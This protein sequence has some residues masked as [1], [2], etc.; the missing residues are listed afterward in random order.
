MFVF[1][2]TVTG[3]DEP[4]GG[5]TARSSGRHTTKAKHSRKKRPRRKR[6]TAGSSGDLTRGHATAAAL[7]STMPVKAGHS[8]GTSSRQL[9]QTAPARRGSGGGG[10]GAVVAQL[11]ALAN[12]EHALIAELARTRQAIQLE[13]AERAGTAPPIGRQQARQ[14]D[15]PRDDFGGLRGVQAAPPLRTQNYMSEWQHKASRT[16]QATVPN[17]LRQPLLTP[18]TQVTHYLACQGNDAVLVVVH[19]HDRP[20]SVACASTHATAQQAQPPQ[21]MVVEEGGDHA[22]RSAM[23]MPPHRSHRHTCVVGRLRVVP[24]LHL[25]QVCEWDRGAC[26]N[27]TQPLLLPS[28][29]A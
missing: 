17:T 22:I 14:A 12:R 1:G 15:L 7:A 26:C 25:V 18:Q 6:G 27:S 3:P 11:G 23:H 21:C 13:L 8:N 24:T 4:P 19:V 20:R 5:A 2:A 29:Q 9:G 16:Q 28:G 10:P